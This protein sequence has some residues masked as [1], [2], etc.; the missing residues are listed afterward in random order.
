[1]YKS[2]YQIILYLIT[3]GYL[4]EEKENI[5]HYGF[6]SLLNYFLLFFVLIISANLNNNLI[7]SIF[8]ISIMFTFRTYVGG[9]HFK[10]SNMCTAISMAISI[11]IPIILN[12]MIFDNSM[13]LLFILLGSIFILCFSPVDT[14]N[15][16]LSL[17]AKMKLKLKI[18]YIIFLLVLLSIF[19]YVIENNIIMLSVTLSYFYCTILLILGIIDNIIIKNK[20]LG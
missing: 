20:D 13:L 9:F 14:K 4:D 18:L 11:L 19:S 6:Y 3:H 5:Y 10:N 1:M 2:S 8:T 16:R 15:R 17:N 7:T 12:Y